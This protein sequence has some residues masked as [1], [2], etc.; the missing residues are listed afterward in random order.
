MDKK[1]YIIFSRVFCEIIFFTTIIYLVKLR[2]NHKE[3]KDR[4]SNV[5]NNWNLNPI[6]SINLSLNDENE[7]GRKKNK[8]I[9]QIK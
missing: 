9:I 2:A 3:I 4:F 5:S 1:I 8:I 6:K 7:R